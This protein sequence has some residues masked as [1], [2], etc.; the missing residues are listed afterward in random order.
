MNGMLQLLDK[1]G[2]E[3]AVVARL[4]H[5]TQLPNRRT[6]D[7]FLARAITAE[8]PL[9]LALLDLDN[10][11]AFNDSRGHN[12][13]DRQLVMC[14][15]Q[16]SALLPEEALLAR[17]G[18]EEFLLMTTGTPEQVAAITEMLRLVTPENQTFSAGVAAWDGMEDPQGLLHRADLALYRAKEHGRD[19]TVIT[20]VAPREL[21]LASN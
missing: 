9:T 12:A 1:Q 18:G 4:D 20:G 10:F 6:A 17:Y 21:A 7:Q 14:A 15:Q 8:S 19:R 2:A 13:G 11:K 3:L 5:L 16:W